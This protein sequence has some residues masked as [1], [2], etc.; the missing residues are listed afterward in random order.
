MN[1]RNPQ[2]NLP[3]TAML[4][5]ALAVSR[6][7]LAL[8]PIL[9]LA[10][11]S[12]GAA[13][14]YFSTAGADAN[15]GT[16]SS[17][18]K[19][20]LQAAADLALPG[21]TILLKRGDAWY[22]PAANPAPLD[23]RDKAGAADN[24]IRFD[25]YGEGAKPVI[26]S[27][28]LLDN[29]GWTNVAGTTTWQH[30]VTGYSDAW[31]LYVNGV[32][33]YKVNTSN[34]SANES[35]VDQPHEW[36]IKPVVAGSSG[37]VYV[38]T[39]STTVGPQNVEVHPVS[40]RSVVLMENTH[41]VSL[42]NLDFRGG[43]QYNVIYVE[44][45]CSNL[46][47][48][49]NIIQRANASGLLVT[50]L[51]SG[52]DEYVSNV[53][54]TNNL[55]DKVWSTQENDP[56]TALS[57]DGLFILHAVDTGLIRGNTVRNWGHVGITLSSYR[58]GFHGVHNFIVEQNDVSAGASGYMHAFDVDGFEGLT[59]N[60]VIRRNLFHD[61]TSTSHA[62][63]SANK[64]YSNVFVGVT[65][66]TQPRQSQQPYGMDLIPWRYTDGNWMSAHDNSIV[67]NTFV[68][69]QQYPIVM[70]D[71]ATST[72]VVDNNL[73]ANN[74]IYSYGV[75]FSGEI[76]LSVSPTVRGVIPVRNNDFWDFNPTAPVARYRNANTSDNYT[77]AAL[78]AAFPQL[79]SGNVQVD[80]GFADV[81]QRD[82][83]LTASSPAAVRSGGL[84]LSGA[85]GADFVDF[86]GNAWDPASPSIGAFQY[87]ATEQP[88]SQ[89]KAVTYST[90]SS[91][92]S[93]G[94]PASYLTDGDTSLTHL[95]AVGNA[96]QLVSATIDLGQRSMVQRLKMWHYWNDGRS[97]HDVIVQLS[98]TPDFS[99]GVTTVF[100]NDT[101]NSAGLGVGQN[102]EYAE[103]SAGK[104]II[105]STPVSGRYARFY[106]AG[107][108]VN[109]FNHYV[110]L[111]VFGYVGSNTPPSI[112]TGP[113][114]QT[115]TAGD[116][117]SF[118]VAATAIPAPSY[119]WR[120][121]GVPI[122]GATGAT[123]T[124]LSAAA[125]DAGGYDVV[126]SNALGTA[127]SGP[128]TLTVNPPLPNV[129]QNLSQGK[130]VAY[131]AIRSGES[132]GTPPS[133]LTDGDTSL[134]HLVAVGNANQL[135]SATITLSQLST[136]TR[137]KMWH[138]WNDARRYHDVIV[139]LSTTADFSSGVTTVFNNDTNNSAGFGVGQ[140]AEYPET[141]A[142]RQII[143]SSPIVARY[144]RFFIAGNSVNA[145]NH[146][147]ELQVFGYANT[148]TLPGIIA[149]PVSQ[150][151]TVGDTVAF[152]VTATGTPSPSYQWRK[153]GVPI[154]G[155]T[156]PTYT[157]PSALTADAGNYD[158]VVHNVVGSVPSAAA[159]L[160]V[161]K[162]VAAIDLGGLVQVYDGGP[163]AVS[164]STDSLEI[165]YAV[166]Y[167]GTP[168][169]PVNAG[170]YSVAVAVVDANYT[171]SV[172]G[173]LVVAPAMANVVL[174][175]LGRIYDGAPKVALVTTSPAG[176][177]VALTYDGAST[178]PINSGSYRVAAAI[179]DPN[180]AGTA[181]GTLVIA[182][183]AA[184]VALGSLSQGYDG[185][186]KAVTATTTP[187]GLS[188]AFT[189][190]GGATAPTNAGS[191]A[192]VGTVNDANY[193]GSA[194]STLTITQAVA[195]AT[196][197]QLA[198][199]YD[200]SPKP[201][202][203]TTAPA[204]LNVATTYNTLTTAPTNVGSYAV[205]TTINDANYTGSAADTLVIS[206]ADAAVS[207]SEL[208]QAYDGTS[209]SVAATT[210]PLNLPL[211]VTYDGNAALPRYPGSYAVVATI[212]DANHQGTANGTLVIK[213]TALVR[214]APTLNGGIAGSLQV[215][216]PE[217]FALN[218]S[219]LVGG[220]LLVPGTPA[221]Q[222][223]GHPVFAG[224]VDAAGS[225][226]P[227][228]STVTLNGNAAL[229][230]LVRRVDAVTMSAVAAPP[231]PSGTRSVSLNNPEQDPGDFSTLRNLTLNGNAGQVSIPA[232]TYGN[233]T[234]N[235]DNGF[236]LGET[237]GTEPVVYNFQGL[238]LNSH[239][240]LQIVG[241]VIVNLASGMALNGGMG[242]SDHPEWLVLNLATDGLTLNGY[243]NCF[244]YVVA[245]N[246]TVTLNGNSTLT[247]GVICDRLM[248]NG[249][250]LL[251]V[252]NQ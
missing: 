160:A 20:S 237:G 103:S 12:A 77:A 141:S 118:S 105:L 27:L 178:P 148:N 137:L 108:S 4:S 216:L 104:E 56:N 110:E 183:A 252:Q 6:K 130:A 200:G 224:A 48:D 158:V 144:A 134:T 170:S 7:M 62:Q 155:A 54:I 189:Y 184:T 147:V 87:T 163:H 94:T 162:A 186:A 79:C 123:Y 24:F 36:F 30:A 55:I 154:V 100:N 136:I 40:A 214:H 2:N 53:T 126:V 117:V 242:S 73:I 226:A 167:D 146:Y 57:G 247:G 120:K 172:T 113:A 196:F 85:L 96:N 35:N 66:T 91:G 13:T 106:L 168:T 140:D 121:G 159:T 107:N 46:V 37:V 228:T 1:T 28:A 230:N 231:A 132:T 138:Y 145:F 75:S 246:G 29:G 70:G 150:T 193:T 223:N 63:G 31:R 80:P 64:Y 175:G 156:A 180:Y 203:V 238:T 199:V 220:D 81:A 34:A 133:Y 10:L 229:R 109:G 101:D 249:N 42:R 112:T 89:G 18:P 69:T 128:A 176:L 213:T 143:L 47:F 151:A 211:T 8:L 153:D 39:G 191:Y 51:A 245:P 124:I 240:R 165:N 161:N 88:L 194:S 72:S 25:A 173:T 3:R 198:Q 169:L 157:I 222:L 233:F 218:G 74:I 171:G 11:P 95:V 52:T 202:T 227:A 142:G 204:G 60:N 125:T 78:N 127:T 32:S 102:A 83:R 23:L 111:Q 22:L 119:Q 195:T 15:S 16:D 192:V 239:S 49:E 205:A 61:Y 71:D 181:S 188:L 187:S 84:D 185:A 250:G 139:Q 115:V 190:D 26:S 215:L 208:T 210:T 241:P 14:Y 212:T 76:G 209:K 244:G 131:N 219:A 221:V 225:A 234:A 44:A 135:V 19:Q 114:S 98:T 174:G 201:V 248:L 129:E 59:T 68:S 86:N 67:N 122:A 58:A 179:A 90:I 43:S 41:Y 5:R 149:G 33:K 50:N 45:V 232:G 166:T 97:Y 65:L 92:E 17:A 197:S 177:P 93:A 217:S 236:T 182:K 164:V 251:S 82:F 207:L 152:S 38:N 99:S 206:V 9:A 116:S 235:S 243:V 21:N